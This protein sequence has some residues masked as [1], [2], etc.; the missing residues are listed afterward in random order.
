MIQKNLA[1]IELPERFKSKLEKD[2]IFLKNYPNLDIEKLILFGSCARGTLKINSDLDLLIITSVTT[3]RYTRGDI[4]SA[5]DEA[6]DNVRTDIVF[7]TNDVFDTST[8]L[9]V[10][11]IKQEGVILYESK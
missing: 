5:L 4:A 7:Y 6:I 2:I 10:K 11:R 1:E 3:D 8:S 9:L